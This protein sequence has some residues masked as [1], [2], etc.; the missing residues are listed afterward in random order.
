MKR[1]N[2]NR[3]L[4]DFFEGG[5]LPIMNYITLQNYERKT[6]SRPL[7]RHESVCELL[8]VYR[9]SGIYHTEKKSYPLQTGDVIFYNQGDLHEV[10]NIEKT[11]IGTYCIGI[12]D[13][14][15]K[16]LPK[17]C[18]V[19]PEGPFVCHSFSHFSSL[20]NICEQIYQLEDGGPQEQIA[21][22]LLCTSFIVIACSL[23]NLPVTFFSVKQEE[24][25]F[26][27]IQ[28]Y[29][30]LHYTEPLTLS[31]AAKALSCSAS[32]LS[33]VFRKASGTTPMQYVIRRRIGHAQTL[34]ISTKYSITQI[35]TLVGYDNPN[36]FS[37]QF[38][39]IVGMSPSHYRDFYAKEAK[40]EKDQF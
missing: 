18:L 1:T 27:K 4:S 23:T 11:E 3:R 16:G 25:L 12:S 21:A 36:Y 29:L 9:G 10:E 8:L 5:H 13:L 24:A 28:R 17:N 2:L 38:S 32:H 7:H 26:Q 31:A 30:D 37:T 15:I 33:H 39:Q 20:L 22:Q 40:G 35:A 14:R 19:Q 6:I 34:L